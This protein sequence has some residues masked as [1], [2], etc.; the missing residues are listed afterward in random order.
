MLPA[1]GFSQIK[2]TGTVTDTDGG[3][4]LIGVNVLIESTS[5]GTITDLDGAFSIDV[6]EKGDVLSFSYTGYATQTVTVGDQTTI[7]IVLES[8]SELLG[9][10]IVVGYGSKR[11][12]DLTGAIASLNSK[13]FEAQPMTRIEDALQGRTTGV[14]INNTNGSPG[15]NAR[16]RIR[17]TNSITGGGNPLIV[18]DGIIGASLGAIAPEDIQN[19]QV[20][21]DASA[22]AL[23]G[24]RGANGVLL[25]TTKKG[26]SSGFQ[27][28]LSTFWG[29]QELPRKVDIVDGATYA[30]LV[31]AD[32]GASIF[33]DEAIAE[34]EQTGGTDWQDEIYRSGADALRQNYTL[35]F[36]GQKDNVNFYISG[37]VADNDG[38][39]L[40]NHYKR[41]AFRSNLDFDLNDKLNVG[42]NITYSKEDAL[43]GFISNLLFAP[44]AA[45]MIFDPTAPPFR[46]DGVTPTS[47]SQ[48]GS[49]APSPLAS[50][51]GRNQQ[52]NTNN[53]TATAFLTYKIVDGLTYYFTGGLR[54]ATNTNTTFINSF[55]DL[56]SLTQANVFNNDFLQVQQTHMLEYKQNFFEKHDFSIR[57][58]YEEQAT[59]NYNNFANGQDLLVENVGIN[60]IGFANTQVIGSSQA[61]QAIQSF[62][63]RLEYEYDNKY[64]LTAT[65][66]ADGASV[67]PEGNK[68]SVFPSIAAA[69]RLSEENFIKNL[70]VFDNLKL[71]ASYGQIGNQGIGAYSS[72]GLLQFGLQFNSVLDNQTAITGVA[73]GRAEN[74]SLRWETTTQLDVGADFGFIDGRL[75]FSADYYQ[76][77]TTD[78]LLFVNLPSYTGL[79]SRLENIGEVENKGFEFELAALVANN[80]T[81]RWDAAFNLSTN[82][83]LALDVGPEGVIFP[84]GA[85][86]GSGS[87]GT[88]LEVGNELGNFYGFINDGVWQVAE[89][90]QAAVYG[91]QAGDVK[92]RDLNNDGV[93]NG[94][95][96][97]IIGNGAPDFIWGFNNTFSYKG[98]DLN[99]FLQSIVGNDIFNLQRA[100]MMGTSGDV[101]TPTHVDILNSWTPENPDTDVPAYPFSNSN[102][103]IPEDSRFIEDGSF[104][105]LR[106]VRLSYTV[107]KNQVFK[108]LTLYVSG[109][110]L[111]TFTDYKGYDPEVSGAGNSNVDLSIDNGTYPNPRVYTVGLNATF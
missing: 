35:S 111:V 86:A 95:D 67:F 77:N 104:I 40:N 45:A 42:L 56:G 37:N 27:A 8:E 105:R 17:G 69:W 28:N 53:A 108:G 92:Y 2:V 54:E 99:I 72:F 82:Q 13:D 19:I 98:F 63:G 74:P 55:A 101:R 44:N 5:I 84:G 52:F 22:T 32:N 76:K 43:N 97:T 109:Q 33:S 91:L 39:L 38:I 14:Q 78:L 57:G 48:F 58:V 15:N 100:I 50:A 51:L 59:R 65:V 96:I 62:I 6:P 110:N 16:I 47:I 34:L 64:L 103:Q 10:V 107:P 49:I 25:I 87:I 29:F 9:E 70:G 30:R 46:E 106:N 18:L 1:L 23:Y 24:S 94:D 89:E 90:S 102:V 11:K 60:N 20:L 66:R 83:T 61:E 88:R 73:P 81:F 85:F 71:R 36:S 12:E 75:T 3:T 26:Q 41:Y 21:K 79:P 80:E 31:N 68:F 4:P 93:I 7:N